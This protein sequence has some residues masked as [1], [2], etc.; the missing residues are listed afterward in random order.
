MQLY[1]NAHLS[2]FNWL[3][4]IT[5]ITTHFSYHL[6]WWPI[7]RY[8]K[9][10]TIKLKNNTLRGLLV[11]GVECVENVLGVWQKLKIVFLLWNSQ[12][13]S[14]WSTFCCSKRHVL[15]FANLEENAFNF[16]LYFV[17]FFIMFCNRISGI[18]M[19]GCWGRDR[20]NSFIFFLQ[21]KG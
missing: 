10:S 13:L 4:S 12:V 11:S 20:E 5:T 16:S 6:S 15:F 9:K 3:L 18:W 1:L 14:A 2:S 19:N 17:L 8:W 21:F 7:V